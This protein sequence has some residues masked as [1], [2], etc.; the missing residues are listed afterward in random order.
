MT[1]ITIT[2]STDEHSDSVFVDA[3]R[4]DGSEVAITE[5]SG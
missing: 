4:E 3:V 1:V 2:H 5:R